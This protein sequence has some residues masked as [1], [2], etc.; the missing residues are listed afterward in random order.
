[1]CTTGR[2][3]PSTLSR[4]NFF[5]STVTHVSK[6]G[7]QN[8]GDTAGRMMVICQP[9]GL[10][11]FFED[12]AKLQGRPDPAKIGPIARKWGMEI[13]GPPMAMRS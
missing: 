3:R 2:T 6:A 7:R 9:A 1:M 11:L 12:V 5:S 8:V 13:L 4:E 10:K